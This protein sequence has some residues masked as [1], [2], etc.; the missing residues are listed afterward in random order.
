MWS[1]LDEIGVQTQESVIKSVSVPCRKYILCIF[2]SLLHFLP[3]PTEAGCEIAHSLLQCWKAI[4][5]LQ[6]CSKKMWTHS[7]L[8][9]LCFHVFIF[10]PHIVQQWDDINV[11]LKEHFFHICITIAS[12]TRITS[13][14]WRCTADRGNFSDFCSICSGASLTIPPEWSWLWSKAIRIWSQKRK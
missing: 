2:F 7:A 9:P 14:A 5:H 3:N 8:S 13:R 1:R 10:M 12:A 6:H 4:I 11:L